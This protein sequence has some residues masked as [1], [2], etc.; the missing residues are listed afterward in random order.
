M[1]YP[2]N[3]SL[4]SRTYVFNYSKTLLMKLLFRR[5]GLL[6]FTMST[7]KKTITIHARRVHVSMPLP[8]FGLSKIFQIWLSKKDGRTNY[9]NLH[10]PD[11]NQFSSVQFSCSVVS[12]SSQPHGLQHARLPCPSPTPGACSNS[13]PS[14]QWCIQPPHPLLPLLLCLSLSQHQGLFQ[15]FL[16]L[17]LVI[18]Y[19]EV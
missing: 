19:I 14:R 3:V 2:E 4:C 9:F 18:L 8:T 7:A 6:K 12:D 10:F 17:W 13:C 1:P 11:T 5:I 15:C 16:A